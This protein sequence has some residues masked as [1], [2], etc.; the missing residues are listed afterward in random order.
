[1]MIFPERTHNEG[2]RAIVA[3]NPTGL[4]SGNYTGEFRNDGI[5]LKGPL[6]PL[7]GDAHYLRETDK[8][9]FCGEEF[10]RGT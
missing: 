6:A 4:L 3:S 5:A 1:M 7:C 9:Q 10:A 2:V 8:L